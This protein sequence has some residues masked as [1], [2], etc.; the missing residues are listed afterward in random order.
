MVSTIAQPPVKAR[1]SNAAFELREA[2]GVRP[3]CWRCH[4]AWSASNA[5]ASSAHSKRFA[6]QFIHASLR[7]WRA[8]WSSAVRLRQGCRAA[9]WLAIAGVTLA[10]AAHSAQVGSS[11]KAP[12][13][14]LDYEM[15][16]YELA[17]QFQPK[18]QPWRARNLKST[19]LERVAREKQRRELDVY[20]YRVGY[21]MSFPLPLARRPTAKELPAAIPGRAYPWLIWL[22]WDLEER[23]RVLHF[24]WRQLRDAEAGALLQQELAALSGWDHYSEVDGNV[25]L[26]TGHLAASLSLALADTAGWDKQSLR[27]ARAAAKALLERD[28][29]PWFE[30]HWSAES[31]GQ[32]QLGNIP[33]IA[34]VRSAQLARVTHSARQAALDAKARQV[35]QAWCRLRTSEAH[36]TEGAAYDGY[37]M[38]SI[39]EWMDGLPDRA[40][41]LRDGHDAFRSLAVQWMNLSLP[42]RPDLQA[43]LGDV[44]PEM[45]FWATALVRL[46]GWYEWRDADWFMHRFPLQRM[47][48]AGLVAAYGQKLQ[49]SLEVPAAEPQE[50]PNALSLRTGWD[51]GDLL[52]LL[53][54]SRGHMGHLHAD[55]GQLILGWQGRFWITDP[56]YQQYRPGAERDYTLGV[57]AHN[58]PVIGGTAQTL[59]TPRV[60][61]LETNAHG[62]QHAQVDLSGCYQGLRPGASVQREL[63]LINDGGRAVVARDTFSSLGQDVEISTCWLGGD[64]LAW[65]WRE[66]WARLSDGRH[67]LWLGTVPD[68]LSASALT[69]HPG[70]RGPLTLTHTATLPYGNGVRWWVFWCDAEAGWTPPSVEVRQGALEFK[71]PGASQAAWSVPAQ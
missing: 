71:A 44:E 62:W 52:A 68:A 70:S 55:G 51:K 45:T 25:G 19:L 29:W 60:L 30:S 14:P 69:R 12:P 42:G 11:P 49:P 2:F 65:A 24:A 34:L 4:P 15:S 47:R 38:D 17:P 32:D 48:A 8:G 28:V 7:R 16:A 27:Q 18:D 35:F 39:T 13:A 26:V 63:W 64:H 21:T 46:A 56:G 57:Q 20:Y 58:A 40:E 54:L 66:G 41:L 5:G 59:R 37:L 50:L 9:E 43:P 3:A 67:A 1:D 33:V 61:L 31:I 23:W 53:G 10:S 36:H 6:W 22:S